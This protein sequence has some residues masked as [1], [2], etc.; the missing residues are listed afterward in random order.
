MDDPAVYHRP[1][2][3]NLNIMIPEIQRADLMDF[4]S[5]DEPW[6]V[7]LDGRGNKIMG[8][9]YGQIRSRYETVEDI[10]LLNARRGRMSYPVTVGNFGTFKFQCKMR[11]VI[12]QAILNIYFVYNKYDKGSFLFDFPLFRIIV[13]PCYEGVF[14]GFAH[15]DCWGDWPNESNFF[16]KLIE[17][18]ISFRRWWIL[19]EPLKEL[20]TA[21]FI[22]V[23]ALG[24]LMVVLHGSVEDKVTKVTNYWMF[25]LEIILL[26][27]VFGLSL[28]FV[29]TPV[30]EYWQA[31]NGN[32][33]EINLQLWQHD[34]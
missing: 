24:A 8:S 17:R 22:I 2:D 15:K 5:M 28:R 20:L 7:C 11:C 14:L 32:Y 34:N 25:I 4:A 19:K 3:N 16:F 23:L 29:A 26:V 33:R 27:L 31:Y 18:R 30:K 10:D 9:L 6:T 12:C 1:I 21:I 13:C